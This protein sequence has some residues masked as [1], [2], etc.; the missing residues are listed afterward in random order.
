MWL[1]DFPHGKARAGVH[2]CLNTKSNTE[3]RYDN[4]VWHHFYLVG[5]EKKFNTGEALVCASKV[6]ESE[7][8][9]KNWLSQL[10]GDIPVH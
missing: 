7:T 1:C 9:I 10:I 4:C 2:Q 3:I 6:H 5:K 8:E